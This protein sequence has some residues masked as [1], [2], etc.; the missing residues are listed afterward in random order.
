MGTME[1][2]HCTTG[3]AGHTAKPKDERQPEISR[4]ME[5]LASRTAVLDD[6]ASKIEERLKPCLRQPCLRSGQP[7]GETDYPGQAMQCPLAQ[8]ILEQD[9]LVSNFLA[10]IGN[11]LNRLEL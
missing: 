6:L 1:N 3:S 11:I 8:K 4:A 5:L 9:V 7:D 10:H 2:C